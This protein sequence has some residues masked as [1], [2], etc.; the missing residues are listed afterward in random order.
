[1][2]I[3][4]GD[5]VKIITGKDKGKEGKV[6]TTLKNKSKVVVEKINII[7]KHVKPNGQ[8]ETGGIIEMEAPIHV[9]NVK[10]VEKEDK[11]KTK[12]TKVV[13][14]AKETKAKTTKKIEK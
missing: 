14:E 6:I 7:K 5:K 9:S 2:K 4:V 3:K 1:M 10:L 13:K 8:N 11:A 12:K